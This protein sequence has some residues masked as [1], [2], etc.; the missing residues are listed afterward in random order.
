MM[1]EDVRDLKK[2]MKTIALYMNTLDEKITTINDFTSNLGVQALKKTDNQMLNFPFKT[3]EDIM[4]N[5]IKGD[6]ALLRHR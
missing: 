5:S 4:N 1:K 3:I 2:S 6:M